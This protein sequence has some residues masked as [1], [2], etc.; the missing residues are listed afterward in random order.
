MPR[1]ALREPDV[2]GAPVHAAT[3]RVPQRMH[4]EAAVEASALLP[5]VEGVPQ[6]PRREP[7]AETAEEERVA[8]GQVP[9][10]L[11]HTV[12]PV[13]LRAHRVREHHLLGRGLLRRAL[14]DAQRDVPAGAPARVEDVADVEGEQLVL[15]EP[16]CQRRG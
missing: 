11:A 7:A 14:E 5:L 3:G 1:E 4:V 6:L 12:E 10:A 9:V 15:A 16:R 13:E 8:R 2:L